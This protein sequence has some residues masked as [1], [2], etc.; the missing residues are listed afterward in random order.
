MPAYLDTQGNFKA[1]QF[2][3]SAYTCL[4]M[5]STVTVFSP[6]RTSSTSGTEECFSPSK[7]AS[8][9]SS[10]LPLVSTQ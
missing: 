5:A 4:S 3:F 2:I 8:I 7:M 9:S 6:C 1:V 10:V